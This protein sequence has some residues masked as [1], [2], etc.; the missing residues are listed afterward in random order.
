MTEPGK[1]ASHYGGD[2]LKERI[3]LALMASGLCQGTLSTSDLA[4]LDQFHSRG[5][6]AT[7][8]L[9][10]RLE[11]DRDMV[12]LDVGSGLGGPSRYIAETFGCTVRGVDLSP[13]FT[14]AATYLASR[15][16]LAHQ[17]S[18]QCGNALALPFEAESFDLVWT[19]HVAM[20]ISDRERMYGEMNRILRPAGRLAIYDVVAGTAGP[21]YFPVPWAREPNTSY[22][23]S[24]DSMRR[25]LESQGFRVISWID[26]T[27]AAVAWFSDRQKMR[28]PT[29]QALGL[30]IAMGSDFGTLS[31]NLARN[32][33][34]G[35][36]GLVEAVLAKT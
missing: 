22:V 14:E 34:E 12:V 3:E 24:A 26:Q 32:L 33:R 31:A 4:G 23:V 10:S 6:S 13:S 18:Y 7:I 17:V 28:P 35:R 20:N 11:I 19:Q 25:T 5:M 8:E 27:E 9:A 36:A 2:G 16:G 15:T 21:L 29:Q 30:H 1:V